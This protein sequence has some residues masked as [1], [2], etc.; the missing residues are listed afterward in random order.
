MGKGIW[1]D[2]EIKSCTCCF[3]PQM[4]TTVGPGPDESQVLPDLLCGW[5]GPKCLSCQFLPQKMHVIR[6]W[7]GR[8]IRT[9]T[10]V[11]HLHGDILSVILMTASNAQAPVECRSSVCLSTFGCFTHDVKILEYCVSKPCS[12]CWHCCHMRFTF[13]SIENS[14]YRPTDLVISPPP[15]CFHLENFLIS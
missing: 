13:V 12:L 9:L 8:S 4:P 1:R 10:R 7:V 2:T 3:S 15:P 5:Q 14:Q 6:S 11:L